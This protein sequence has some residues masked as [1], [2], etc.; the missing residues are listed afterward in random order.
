MRQHMVNGTFH[1]PVLNEFSVGPP[2]LSSVF[3]LFALT[4]PFSKSEMVPVRW[5]KGSFSSVTGGPFR[6]FRLSEHVA[7]K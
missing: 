1:V 6:F 7:Y 3:V 4:K 5:L 2:S